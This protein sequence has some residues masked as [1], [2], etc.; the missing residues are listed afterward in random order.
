MSEPE[1]RAAHRQSPREH[2]GEI[3][4]A[5]LRLA[6]AVKLGAAQALSAHDERLI[7][8]AAHVVDQLLVSQRLAEPKLIGDEP[9]A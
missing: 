4:I 8:A 1:H 5:R 2:N 6:G 3:E 7:R 9:E